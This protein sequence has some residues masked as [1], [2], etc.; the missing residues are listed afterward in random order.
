MDLINKYFVREVF[1]DE[2]KKSRLVLIPKPGRNLDASS[3]YRPICLL[4]TLAKLYE[5][6]ILAR[7]EEE[8]EIMG[9]LSYNNTA[10]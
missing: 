1:S 6:I 4:N 7:L 10:S 5:S 3:E 9:G 2:W 8:I